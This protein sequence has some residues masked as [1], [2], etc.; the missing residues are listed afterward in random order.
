MKKQ[1][2]LAL[3]LALTVSLSA[4]QTV[5]ASDDHGDEGSVSGSISVG[6]SFNDD[7]SN[8]TIASEYSNLSDRD[9]REVIGGS[10]H[11][12]SGTTVIGVEGMYYGPDEQEYKGHLDL[13]RIL[14]IHGGYQEFWHR[15]GQDELLNMEAQS[16]DRLQGALLWHTYEYAPGYGTDSDGLTNQLVPD[17][18]F[19]IKRSEFEATGK[20]KFPTI[21]GLTIGVHQRSEK[22]EGNQQAMGMSKCGSC[23]I[24]AHDKDIDETT[25]DIK[26]FVQYDMGKLS[27][28]YSY[29][30]RKFIN[31]SDPLMHYYDN[32]YNPL[33]GGTGGG[34]MPLR[35]NYWDQ[36]VEISKTP[37]TR[38]QVHSVK[39]KY[40][41][42]VD[43]SVYA[44]YVYANME[45][46]D[47]SSETDRVS[48]G[49][50][51]LE[52]DYNAGMLTWHNRFSKSL[53]MN[54]TVR[55][56]T[57]DADDAHINLPN[58]DTGMAVVAGT[59]EDFT[60]KSDENRDI[61]TMKADLRYRL[62]KDMTL[63]GGVE[64]EDVDR[65]YCD[66][67]KSSDTTTYKAKAGTT[68]RVAKGLR[69][70]ADYKFTYVDDPYTFEDSVYPN[71]TDPASP[72][73]DPNAAGVTNVPFVPGSTSGGIY[74]TYV[75]GE[76][77]LNMSAEPEYEHDVK[78]K[79]NWNVAAN[80][81][82]GGYVRYTYGDNDSDINYRY[83]DEVV[84]TGL[85]FTFSPMDKM[86]ATFG[87]NYY[88][89]ETDSAFYIPF[90]HG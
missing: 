2:A 24:V 20:M 78:L 71:V 61:F 12:H 33:S 26:P 39:A 64:Y 11:I 36:S 77:A 51:S 42:S 29:L 38:K 52:T 41:V 84:D 62:T 32:A 70:K 27:L 87:Y 83:T 68:W 72:L 19:G 63:R 28:E 22:R 25:R 66:F 5:M 4:S 60:R 65:E 15:L 85:D 49:D 14:Q 58:D 6:A 21:P 40:D 86:T 89:Q 88:W 55:Y 50:G 67:L 79:G 90:Y 18:D 9:V 45:N 8:K 47:A 74:S 30:Y 75:Y 59:P 31:D 53:M 80:M 35:M 54:A 76:R 3:A 37:E 69:L 34:S 16:A 48:Y 44:G 73:Y 23:H 17:Y 57:I 82:L 13:G 81:D 46:K 56:Q 10:L 7:S 43:Q 1:Y